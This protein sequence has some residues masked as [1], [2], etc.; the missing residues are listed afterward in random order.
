M[1]DL[2][3]SSDKD[4]YQGDPDPPQ[5][6]LF[7]DP[8]NACHFERALPRV[9]L[10]IPADATWEPFHALFAESFFTERRSGKSD[11]GHGPR[12]PPTST[13]DFFQYR[14]QHPLI[15]PPSEPSAPRRPR[16]GDQAVR[17]WQT[18]QKAQES[19]RRLDG[20]LIQHMEA[21]K[22]TIKRLYLI[23]YPSHEQGSQRK[24]LS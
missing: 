1:D 22:D 16:T 18:N 6:S 12:G 20:M 7:V 5:A 17:D 9:Q 13:F 8:P 11:Q 10:K 14:Q 4:S 19:L 2:D 23:T 24:L 3:S 21:E 15:S